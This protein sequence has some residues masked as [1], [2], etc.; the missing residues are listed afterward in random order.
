MDDTLNDAGAGDGGSVW[1][2]DAIDRLLTDGDA[3]AMAWYSA[4]TGKPIGQA[5]QGAVQLQAGARSADMAPVT[6]FAFGPNVGLMIV[7][8]VIAG[9]VLVKS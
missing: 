3:Y 6:T 1:T 7:L 9:V 4:V 5:V 8:A 2:P